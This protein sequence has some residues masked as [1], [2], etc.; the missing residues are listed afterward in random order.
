MAYGAKVRTASGG[1]SQS[2]RSSRTR[3]QSISSRSRGARVSSASGSSRSNQVFD[4]MSM[5]PIFGSAAPELDSTY[6]S[7]VR[8]IRTGGKAA[9]VK[10]PTL[11]PTLVKMAALVIVLVAVLSFI[12][13]ILTSSAVVTM[14]ENDTI[15]TQITEARSTGIS[16]EMEQSVLKN[17][18]AIRAQAKQM[19]MSAPYSATTITLKPD[20]VAIENGETLS[21]SGTIK[22][23]VQINQ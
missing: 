22:N 19:N 6:E 4:R 9:T 2:L 1:T 5:R 14:I 12:R 18:S 17:P 16:L 11:L 15:S 8:V 23:V 10:Q 20:I 3:S 13:I 7:D 21:L